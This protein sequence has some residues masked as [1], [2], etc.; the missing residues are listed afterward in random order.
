MS[1]NRDFA[2]MNLNHYRDLCHEASVEAGWWT[3]LETGER[4]IRNRGE[5]LMLIVTELDEWQMTMETSDPDKHLPQHP[6][7][8]VELADTL[9]RLWD[10]AGGFYLDLNEA[11]PTTRT[12]KSPCR[13]MSRM[14]HCL[15]MA[16]ENQRKDL[17]ESTCIAEAIDACFAFHK[18][19]WKTTEHLWRTIDDKMAYN[20]QRADHRPENRKKAGGKKC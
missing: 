16:M 17:D 11:R 12:M 18:A 3:D 10:Y 15:S 5:M 6:A 8:R 19:N 7:W 4:I 1:D 9:I 14:I 2:E 20:T 13:F